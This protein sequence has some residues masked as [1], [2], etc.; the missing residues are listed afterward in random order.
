MVLIVGV[1][2]IVLEQCLQVIENDCVVKIKLAKHS[3][4]ADDLNLANVLESHLIEAPEEVLGGKGLNIF[5]IFVARDKM[6]QLRMV[7]DVLDGPLI[8]KELLSEL[9]KHLLG[10]VEHLFFRYLLILLFHVC[11]FIRD[12][13]IVMTAKTLPL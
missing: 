13:G 4:N 9:A 3:Q 2:A 8:L 12:H 11:I 7:K 6:N 10:S 5:D 1:D